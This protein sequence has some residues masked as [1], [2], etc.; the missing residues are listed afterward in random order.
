MREKATRAEAGQERPRTLAGYFA[1]AFREAHA[2]RP[3]SFYLL[4][5]IPVALMAGAHMLEMQENPA[6]FALLL[7]A[8]FVF[9]GIIVLRAIMDMADIARKHHVAERETWSA[10]IGDPKFAGD[11]GR[12]VREHTDA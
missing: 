8:M 3:L 6:R 4:L 5:S 7:S 11:L 12:R 10:T 1:A 9:F 2:R